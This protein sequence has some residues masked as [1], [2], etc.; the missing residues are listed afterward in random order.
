VDAENNTAV[1][2]VRAVNITYGVVDLLIQ[3][4]NVTNQ[5]AVLLLM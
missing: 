4:G 1:A 2:F 3:S 5:F